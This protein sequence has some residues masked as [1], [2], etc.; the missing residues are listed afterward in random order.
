M[1]NIRADLLEYKAPIDPNYKG[2]TSLQKKIY[3][4][5][6]I[7]GANGKISGN[8]EIE[9]V[10]PAGM[11]YDASRS[12]FVFNV[13]IG[14]TQTTLTTPIA[15]QAPAYNFPSCFFKTA[16]V[17][18]NDL[19]AN[20]SNNVP[21]DD[22]VMKRM[23]Y[24][25]AYNT[26]IGTTGLLYGSDTTRF[27]LV[28]VANCVRNVIWQPLC[29][30]PRDT[31][32]PENCKVR[33]TMTVEPTL[34]DPANSS[35]FV[36]YA[37]TYDAGAIGFNDIYYVAYFVK[38]ETPTPKTVYLPTYRI[39]SIPNNVATTGGTYQVRV[40]PSTYKLITALQ[41][42]SATVATGKDL[43]GFY[44]GTA[45]TKNSLSLGLKN[46]Q[47]RFGGASYPQNPYDLVENASPLI[48]QSQQAYFDFLG[49]TGAFFDASGGETYAEWQD[50]TGI[51]VDSH[52]RLFAFDIIH[53]S[54]DN[55]SN[56]ELYVNGTGLTTTQVW[57]F[58]IAK[59]VIGISFD[60]RNQPV[61]TKVV[62]TY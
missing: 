48:S 23:L 33:Y 19:Q 38:T 1:E 4:I 40:P 3:P 13:A 8:L 39:E 7:I 21:Q 15:L 10:V 42:N 41:S 60:E 18:I 52:G 45:L 12:Y 59:N 22:T 30:L 58:A 50:S 46:I 62:Q 5:T 37:T 47:L 51:T 57:T 6:N 26:T 31:I 14:T 55:S 24:S 35:A 11:K 27:N 29:L 49:A 20:V 2:I 44:S 61:E 34:H 9:V 28:N 54:T 25:S 43:T 56:V 53:P 17:L 32:V 36:S 16:R